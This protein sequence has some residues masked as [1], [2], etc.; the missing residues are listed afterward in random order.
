[1]QK[2]SGNN[3]ADH[4]DNLSIDWEE[5]WKTQPSDEEL[6]AMGIEIPMDETEEDF[7]NRIDKMIEEVFIEKQ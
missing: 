4:S 2:K 3:I 1:M 7:F 6:E 5:Y